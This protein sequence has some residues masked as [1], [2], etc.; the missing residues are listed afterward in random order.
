M[1]EVKPVVLDTNFLALL[2]K[3]DVDCELVDL[4]IWIYG[5]TGIADH[6]QLLKMDYCQGLPKLLNHHGI[7]DEQVA[8]FLWTYK[9]AVN[10]QRIKKDPVDLKLILF[11]IDNPGAM[12]LTCETGLLALAEDQKVRHACFKAATHKLDTSIG[13]GLFADPA[14]RTSLMFESEGNH[15]FFHYSNNKRC[16]KCDALGRC[17]TRKSPPRRDVSN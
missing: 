16:P 15:P 7:S 13:G 1:T 2:S 17:A 11:A 4:I 12:F 5:N 14:Y 3:I 8:I 9:G 6:P 10:L